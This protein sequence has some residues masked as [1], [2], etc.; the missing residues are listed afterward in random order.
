MIFL[1]FI[2]FFVVK[3]IFILYNYYQRRSDSV[4]NYND[5]YDDIEILDMLSDMFKNSQD[6]IQQ[7]L[8]VYNKLQ[9]IL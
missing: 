9:V 2:S 6:F 8:G 4:K 5:D 7:I 1:K 3:Y